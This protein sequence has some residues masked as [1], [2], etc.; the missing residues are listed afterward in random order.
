MNIGKG[1]VFV[2]LGIILLGLLLWGGSKMGIPFGKM[3]GDIHVQREKY[4]VNFP[5]MTSILVSIGLT[6][7]LNLLLWLWRK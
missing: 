5:L 1:L 7:L 4:S 6:I 3:P 2:G